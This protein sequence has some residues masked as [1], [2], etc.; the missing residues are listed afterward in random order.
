MFSPLPHSGRVQAHHCPVQTRSSEGSKA[1]C[2]QTELCVMFPESH[3]TLLGQ[4]GLSLKCVTLLEWRA[5]YFGEGTVPSRM[6][7]SQTCHSRA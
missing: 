7:V 1:S 5:S 4:C 6:P 3:G 2:E